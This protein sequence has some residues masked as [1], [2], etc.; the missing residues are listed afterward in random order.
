M[1]KN[2]DRTGGQRLQTVETNGRPE[3]T[4]TIDLFRVKEEIGTSTNVPVRPRTHQ[5]IYHN[6]QQIK[7][8]V[9][10]GTLAYTR[11]L[12]L[13]TTPV[14]ISKCSKFAVNF[15]SHGPPYQRSET[16]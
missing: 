10:I 12:I 8:L 9:L 6:L 3:W 2:W 13:K 7:L 5:R 4:R 16:G 15:P 11:E 1:D 14:L